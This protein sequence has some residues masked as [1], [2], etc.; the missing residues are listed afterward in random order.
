VTGHTHRA[1]SYQRDGVLHVNPGSAGPERFGHSRTLA[2]LH[3]TPPAQDGL[4][5]QV[6]VEFVVVPQ[7]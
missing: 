1:E 6:D 2:R 3:I 4:P 5:A 7:V